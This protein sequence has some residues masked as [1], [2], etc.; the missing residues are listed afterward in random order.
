MSREYSLGECAYS[1]MIRSKQTVVCDRLPAAYV[2]KRLRLTRGIHFVNDLCRGEFATYIIAVRYMDEFVGE[3]VYSEI[4]IH[5]SQ[6]ALIACACLWIAE[7]YHEDS[8]SSLANICRAWE[9][10]GYVFVHQDILD[11]EVL[12][13]QAFNWE[14]DIPTVCHFVGKITRSLE[15]I[16]RDAIEN[17]QLQIV[18]F[19]SEIAIA[20]KEIA[21]K[22]QPFSDVAKKILHRNQDRGKRSHTM[23][24]RKSP[25]GI[26]KER[27][28]TM[29]KREDNLRV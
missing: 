27:S 3:T 4:N 26:H 28:H 23:K 15:F 2:A 10:L 22:I 6:Y 7:K 29:K 1:N 17:L 5:P 13:L 14:V 11:M 16:V 25:N 12:I 9:D 8:N 20:C 18:Y 24:P 19:P 21:L